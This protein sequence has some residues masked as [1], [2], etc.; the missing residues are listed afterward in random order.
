MNTNRVSIS[1]DYIMKHRTKRGAWTRVQILALGIEWPPKAGWINDLE[2]NTISPE[3]AKQ[4][5]QGKVVTAK[6]DKQ[7]SN[8]F[9]RVGDAVAY[10]VKHQSKLDSDHIKS[11]SAVIGNARNRNKVV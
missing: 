10:L 6:K 7:Q 9:I 2:G 8:E 11:M 5:E 3:M 1:K 4:F